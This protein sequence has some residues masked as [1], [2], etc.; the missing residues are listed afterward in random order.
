MQ[1]IFLFSYGNTNFIIAEKKEICEAYQN[2]RKIYQSTWFTE[3]GIEEVV[4]ANTSESVSIIKK[5]TY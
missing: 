1:C 5:V 2:Q 3:S 4:G